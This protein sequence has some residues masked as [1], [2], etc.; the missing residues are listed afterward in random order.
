MVPPL[1][2]GSN[3]MR[4]PELACS[5]ALRRVVVPAGGWATSSAELTTGPDGWGWGEELPPHAVMTRHAVIV[6]A[7]EAETRYLGN[8][9]G[10]APP[11]RSPF[12]H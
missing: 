9:Y 2:E 8:E 12:F 1:S 6:N 7:N 11:E 10:T 5:M 4:S 3:V